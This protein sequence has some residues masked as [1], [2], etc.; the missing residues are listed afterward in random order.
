MIKAFSGVI[1]G[2]VQGVGFRYS[3]KIKA[4]E[5][6]LT[7][8]VRNLPDESVE[9]LANGPLSALEQFM[10]Y[11]KAGPIGSQVESAEFQWLPEPQEYRGF[12]IRG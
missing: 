12:E 9:I 6:Q 2:R 4:D 8:W 10:H 3:A 5:L 11:L 1:K 7:G